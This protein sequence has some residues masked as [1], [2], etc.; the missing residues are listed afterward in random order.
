MD[1]KDFKKKF[2]FTERAGIGFG[3]PIA[4]AYA[5]ILTRM[6]KEQIPMILIMLSS[7]AVLDVV[8]MGFPLS[9][10]VIK[11]PLILIEKENKSSEEKKTLFKQ[12][13]KVP[14][15]QALAMFIRV[16]IGTIIAGCILYFKFKLSGFQAILAVLFALYGSYIAGL[17]AYYLTEK[18][19]QPI[20]ESLEQEVNFTQ[21]DLKQKT[22]FGLSFSSNN[23]FF[24]IL[25]VIFTTLLL[26]LTVECSLYLKDPM[27]V[28]RF[29]IAGVTIINILSN[30]F[31]STFVTKSNRSQLEKIITNL[32]VI[33]F[34]SGNLNM[35]S[36]TTIKDEMEYIIYLLN[37]SFKEVGS[38]IRRIQSSNYI[39]SDASRNLTKMSD[40]MSNTSNEQAASVKEIVT[41]ME[42]NTKLVSEISQ[43][44]KEIDLRA[45]EINNDVDTGVK[46]IEQN[47]TQ[48]G[49]IKLA[50]QETVQLIDTLNGQIKS[51]WEVVNIITSIAH[52]T[53][54]IAFN[55][56][57]EATA[58]GDMGKNFQI[59]ATEIRRLADNTVDS[60]A[61]IKQFIN[62][63]QGSSE[64]LKKTSQT[65]T[66]RI[67]DGLK[68]TEHLRVLMDSLRDKSYSTNKFAGSISF[69]TEQQVAAFHQIFQT[70]KQISRGIANF[71]ESTD[72]INE[73]THNMTELICELEKSINKFSL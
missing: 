24:V 21:E 32:N 39:I 45:T 63:I 42:D 38:M 50:D 5:V 70:L 25:P 4:A 28:F 7:V 10:I 59:V 40:E 49:M 73:N 52:Q 16:A 9:Y 44:L 8:F 11:K 27:T 1:I 41:T 67:A 66:I 43:D 15:N 60:T 2:Y 20:L 36:S 64:S 58:A 19:I 31:M 51:I 29:K 46:L 34:S 71:A 22:H 14:F 65:G 13:H 56:E 53:K 35:K 55:A 26:Y 12:L 6:P 18:I 17:Y 37:T 30:F 48:M 62:E 47:K 23:L 57:L 72:M 3:L 33:A 68:L 61:K 69:K 54:I